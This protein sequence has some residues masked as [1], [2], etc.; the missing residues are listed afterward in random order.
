[1][2]EEQ[3]W[4]R[5]ELLSWARDNRDSVPNLGRLY[6]KMVSEGADAHYIYAGYVKRLHE[7]KRHRINGIGAP[8][9]GHDVVIQLDDRINIQVWH[10]MNA[11]GYVMEGELLPGTPKSDAVRRRLGVPTD[12]G[13]VPTDFEYD[14]KNICEKLAQ[15]PDGTLGIL[16]LCG[17]RFD[18]WVPLQQEE[19]PASKC[20]LNITNTGFTELHHSPAFGHLEEINS[21]AECLGLR[22]IPAR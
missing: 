9:G 22:I 2:G 3:S 1:M 17:G 7:C 8:A 20:I 5:A 19:I 11:H 13:G 12:L 6:N 4:T 10:G 14:E 15:L 18:Y 16:L 21:I